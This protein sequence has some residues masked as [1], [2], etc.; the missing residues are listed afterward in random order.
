M[1]FDCLFIIVEYSFQNPDHTRR[2]SNFCCY[3]IINFR[4]RLKKL[5]CNGQPGGGPLTNPTALERNG[6]RSN[7]KNNVES[8]IRLIKSGKF[9]R[10]LPEESPELS[11]RTFSKLHCSHRE[12]CNI[13]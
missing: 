12:S 3:N 2:K 1:K 8:S 9:A 5:W 11:G 13:R 10:K 7:P 4:F 6:K